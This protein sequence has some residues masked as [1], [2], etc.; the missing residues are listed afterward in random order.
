MSD[1]GDFSS[2]SNVSLKTR[3]LSQ[4]CLAQTA[5]AATNA[6]HNGSEAL[7]L[8][9][10]VDVLQAEGALLLCGPVEM[11]ALNLNESLLRG[12]NLVDPIS[13]LELKARRK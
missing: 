1:V 10:Q 9:L 8:N 4:N 11:A 6:T 2:S 12:L 13:E 7:A 3:H 5:L